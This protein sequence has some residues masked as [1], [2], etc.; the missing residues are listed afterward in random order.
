MP[1]EFWQLD[2]AECVHRPQAPE[3]YLRSL[4]KIERRVEDVKI[5]VLLRSKRKNSALKQ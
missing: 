3:N 4:F 5:R 1:A 2:C